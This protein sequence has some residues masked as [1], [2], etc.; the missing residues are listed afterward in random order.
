MKKMI[1][2]FGACLAVILGCVV[3]LLVND[4]PK[5]S[6]QNVPFTNDQNVELNGKLYQ[7]NE[8]SDTGIFFA[9]G[10]YSTQSSSKPMVQQL[11]KSGCSVFTFDYSQM[12][13]SRDDL[14]KEG[15]SAQ[16]YKDFNAALAAFKEKTGLTD[17]KIVIFGYG[18]GGRLTLQNLVDTRDVYKA[19]L[20][21]SPDV[22]YSNRDRLEDGKPT[23]DA[24]IDA[25]N[26]ESMQQPTLILATQTDEIG[27][28]YSMTRLYNQLS[29][30]NIK[31]VGGK[32]KASRNDVSISMLTSGYHPYQLSTR[33][34]VKE[35][36]SFMDSVGIDSNNIPDG[37]L[38]LRI[39]S[40]WIMIAFTAI[41]LVLAC[42]I[43]KNKTWDVTYRVDPEGTKS[44][45]KLLLYK[46]GGLVG[47]IVIAV[48]F[49]FVMPKI[50]T[51]I[52]NM[53]IQYSGLLLGL[54]VVMPLLYKKF[55][56]GGEDGDANSVAIGVGIPRYLLS[57]VVVLAVI[58]VFA[59]IMMTGFYHTTL[60]K[61]ELIWRGLF[62]LI[63]WAGFY[64]FIYEKN[65][66]VDYKAGIGSHIL[67]CV[68]QY[69]PFLVFI[70]F[71]AIAGNFMQLVS[72][73][74]AFV[75]LIIVALMGNVINM[76]SKS[77]W[78]TSLCMSITFQI[79]ISAIAIL[80]R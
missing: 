19:V 67:W 77:R 71:Y 1:V 3:T 34:I 56:V 24:L 17:D 51:N 50:I 61:N 41:A 79:L 48:I 49:S 18:A 8:K 54:A 44:S 46:L 27:D 12:Y 30:D 57:V 60:M 43:I 28:A 66:L 42:F 26:S 11:M 38:Q 55:D 4:I 80:L 62:I 15:S 74:H 33:T 58:G 20:L 22:R 2:A 52:P 72:S 7:S 70:P 10:I 23:G 37:K 63:S 36:G 31:R 14:A 53:N 45:F 40:W 21:L 68:L 73:F 47:V 76:L 35:V 78:F 13:D 75:S 9:G 16:I 64:T 59:V 69:L 5:G 25:L 6:V 29:T 32:Y 65:K 39:V